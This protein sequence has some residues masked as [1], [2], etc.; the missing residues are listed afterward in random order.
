MARAQTDLPCFLMKGPD[1]GNGNMHYSII[2]EPQPAGSFSSM[3]NAM[4]QDKFV[5]LREGIYRP[6]GVTYGRFIATIVKQYIKDVLRSVNEKILQRRKQLNEEIDEYNLKLP[7]EI[8]SYNVELAARVEQHNKTATKK[9]MIKLHKSGKRYYWN[10]TKT[11]AKL[12]FFDED[13]RSFAKESEKN[14]YKLLRNIRV[15][16]FH[17][18]IYWEPNDYITCEELERVIFQAHEDATRVAE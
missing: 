9:D 16:V 18:D 14:G 12:R 17:S 1:H 8:K 2:C 11:Y 6:N 10:G 15:I 4:Q 7:E 3:E 5:L 13:K